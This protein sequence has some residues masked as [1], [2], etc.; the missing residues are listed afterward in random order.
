MN[1]IHRSAGQVAVSSWGHQQDRRKENGAGRTVARTAPSATKHNATGPSFS[2]AVR[3]IQASWGSSFS[4]D[5]SQGIPLGYRG[6]VRPADLTLGVLP[7]SDQ[8]LKAEKVMKLCQDEWRSRF[9]VLTSK[10]LMLT[11]P[12]SEQISDKIPLV[13]LFSIIKGICAYGS[14][15]P[16]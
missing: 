14:S 8:R 6:G 10:E 9:L 1:A 15:I 12:E 2:P 4:I 13:S 16:A 3:S 7:P 11:L 5:Q